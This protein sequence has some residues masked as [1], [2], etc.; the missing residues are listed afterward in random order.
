MVL[1]VRVVAEE[2]VASVVVDEASQ[3]VRS[4]GTSLKEVVSKLTG[5][6]RNGGGAT[7]GWV[8]DSDPIAE[9]E[10][11]GVNWRERKTPLPVNLGTRCGCVGLGRR[12]EG[13]GGG[14][15]VGEGG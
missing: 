6:S 14:G 13:R 1:H 5:E 4:L 10:V 12:G 9:V 11:G 3:A 8:V 7:H 2:E 15:R